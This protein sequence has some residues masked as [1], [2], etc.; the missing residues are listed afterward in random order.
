MS[1]FSLL[2]LIPVMPADDVFSGE[3]IRPNQNRPVAIAGSCPNG[4]CPLATRGA[5]APSAKALHFTSTMKSIS[6]TG[7]ETETGSKDEQLLI[8]LSNKERTSAGLPPLTDDPKLMAMAREQAQL[9]ARRNQ[10][11]HSVDGQSFSLRLEKSG[12]AFSAAGENIAEGQRDAAEAVS[13]WMHSPGHRANLL[14]REFTQIGTAV[15][16]SST[17]HRYSVQV[18][19]RPLR[20]G[21]VSNAAAPCPNCPRS[22]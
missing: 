14:S 7:E 5:A 13:D 17:G 20:G 8:E 15:A 6:A 12:Y 10:I 19:G 18:F 1:L 22:H 3:Q 2:L 21:T 16:V 4:R 11:S 9:M